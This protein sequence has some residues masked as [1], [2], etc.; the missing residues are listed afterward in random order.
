MFEG[1]GD[2]SPDYTA[3]DVL[4][5]VRQQ[6]HTTFTRDGH[7]LHVQHS[8]TLLEVRLEIRIIIMDINTDTTYTIGTSWIQ[9]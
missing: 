9:A 8:I 7:H 3:G 4:F 2:A 5:V 6:P 1:E